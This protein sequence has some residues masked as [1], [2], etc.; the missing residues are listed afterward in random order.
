MVCS[1]HD[2]ANLLQSTPTRIVLSSFILST[3]AFLTAAELWRERRKS[4]LRRWPAIFVPM[5]HGAVFLTPIPLASL[6]PDDR[7]IASLAGG[8]ITVF[9]LETMLV[10][11]WRRVYRSCACQGTNAAYA[12]GCSLD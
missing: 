3:Y 5:L 2:S 6:M 4:V 10:C 11:R 12:A 9:A 8:W 7:G 1:V